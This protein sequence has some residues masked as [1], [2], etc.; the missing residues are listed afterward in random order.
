MKYVK[1]FSISAVVL[2]IL[3]EI[4]V[5]SRGDITL[6]NHIYRFVSRAPEIHINGQMLSYG[7]TF[8]ESKD[9]F[10]PYTMSDEGVQLYKAKSIPELQKPPWIF[11]IRDHQPVYRYKFPKSGF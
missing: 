4:T 11:V 3:L 5:W 8:D 2:L 10:V 6:T 9:Y 1:F 7:G